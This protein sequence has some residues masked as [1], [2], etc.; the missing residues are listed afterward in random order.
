MALSSGTRLGPYQIL[1]L[2]GTGGMGEVYRAHDT[3]LGRDVA[4]K[5]LRPE[6][7]ADADRIARFSREAKALASLNHPNIAQ[8]HGLEQT[9]GGQAL[10]MELVDGPTLADRIVAGATPVNEAL[11]IAQQIAQG[12][13]AAHENGI[14]HRD[15]KPANIKVRHDGTVKILDFGLA[16]TL[17][18]PA[19]R[20][21]SA[22][23]SP[24]ISLHATQAGVLL[25]TVAYM[26]PEQARGGRVDARVDI[27]AFGCVLYEAVTGVRAF[28]GD[29]VTD[30]IVGVIT[31]E[32]D[33]QAI[34]APAA[35]LRPLLA[36]CLKKD[37]KERLQAIG[38]ARI[39]LEEL[40][41]G[42]PENVPAAAAATAPALRRIAV[43]AF[44]G[45]LCGAAIVA[46]AI[47]SAAYPHVPTS[48][49]SPRF[50][51]IPPAALPLAL[52]G[53]DRD[54][55]IS[56][57]SH[58]LVYRA[59]PGL[60]LLAVRPIDQLDA[61]P[62]A[63]IT[64]A[65][66]PFFSAD[67]QWIGFF[68]GA[69]LKKAPVSGGPAVTIWPAY[70][71]PRGASWGDDNTI[72]FATSDTST[73]LMVVAPSGGNPAVLTRPD[74]T[75]GERSHCRPS[76]LPGGRG[77]LF[78]ILPVNPTEPPRIAVLDLKTRQYRVI[79]RGGSQAEYLSTGHLL[80]AAAG[81]LHAVRFDVAR[82]E[83]VGEPVPVAD[84]VSTGSAGAA[85]YAVSITGTLAYVPASS[86]RRPRR[87]VWVDR[88][89]Q[90][91]T[92]GAPGRLYTEPRLSPDG[93]RVA[94]SI[95]DQEQDVWI[96]DLAHEILNRLTFDPA[97]DSHPVWTPD[98]R[99]VVF[100]S[101]R[102]GPFNLF[103]ASADGTGVTER[104]T[105]SEDIQI[106]SFVVP[107]GTGIVGSVTAPKTNGDVVLFPFNAGSARAMAPLVRTNAIEFNP[108][109][110][111]DG[112]YMAYQS[113]ESGREAIYVRPFPDVDKG[114]WEVSA[115]GGT[116]PV[117]ARNGRELFY[118]DLADTMISVPVQTSGGKFV[119]GR[120]V[121]LFETGSGASLTSTRDFDVAPDGERFLMIKE[122]VARNTRPPGM[123]VVEHWFEL[124]NA[125]LP[126]GR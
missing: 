8:I 77:I 84:D 104:L 55:A 109:I 43:P 124:L 116:R 90:E 19:S 51:V 93:K 20:G 85:N 10:V 113:N 56:P 98:G 106:P 115:A 114:R 6:V 101:Q 71:V 38:D 14:I 99:R 5:L 57:D 52:Q 30:T 16:K 65:R 41:A 67:G 62:I 126:R 72:V 7:A 27:W 69:G 78:T 74:A 108:E 34:P 96:L 61:Q 64:N 1:T 92:I 42:T 40:I 44:G 21:A 97:L 95:R 87:I 48:V 23:T 86:T 83:T 89:G 31:R 11:S 18:P 68:D 76:V 82:L 122:N 91:A 32:P 50:E 66:Q 58:F 26:A 15:L 70:V 102:A 123:V 75:K 28:K 29:D 73:G 25:G 100:A 117:W 13:E 37:V 3:R 35:A 121:K 63:G 94:V 81:A 39:Q 49:L 110:S 12:L 118:V 17:E 9:D 111:P 59:D 33:W 22:T 119:A 120:P 36:R 4:V 2:L 103:V 53:A 24:T 112:R 54:I 45:A 79:V 46:I 105:T 47:W 107:D 80:Y 60:G 125:R 88:K